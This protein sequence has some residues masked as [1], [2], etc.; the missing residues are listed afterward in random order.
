[1]ILKS[2]I[3]QEDK[4]RLHDILSYPSLTFKKLTYRKIPSSSSFG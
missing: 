1:M 3:I 2:D 4:M